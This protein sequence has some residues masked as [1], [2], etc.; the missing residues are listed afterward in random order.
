MNGVD[1]VQGLGPSGHFHGDE[2]QQKH[3][4]PTDD[5]QNNG[6]NGNDLFHSVGF[7][8]IGCG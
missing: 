2:G 6:Q 5:G 4:N 3:Q 1:P 7:L 8:V